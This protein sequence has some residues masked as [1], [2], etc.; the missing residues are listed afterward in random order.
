VERGGG[1][2]EISRSSPIHKNSTADLQEGEEQGIKSRHFSPVAIDYKQM[3]KKG[4][5]DESA[6]N[7]VEWKVEHNGCVSRK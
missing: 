5:G 7:F 3:V 4:E 6:E 2:G 1:D